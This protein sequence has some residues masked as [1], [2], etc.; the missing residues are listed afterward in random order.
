MKYIE[1]IMIGVLVILLALF[2]VP[3]RTEWTAET[4]TEAPLEFETEPVVETFIVETTEAERVLSAKTR[5]ITV[6]WHDIEEIH[7]EVIRI[8]K[9]GQI[10]SEETN[11]QETGKESIV[12]H[13]RSGEG[14]Q[15]FAETQGEVNTPAVEQTDGVQQAAQTAPVPDAE[16]AEVVGTVEAL[17]GD[18]LDGQPEGDA[19]STIPEILKASLDGAG[20]GWWYPYACAQIEQESHW[21]PWAVN[22]NNLDFGLLQFRI[23]FWGEPEDIFD[24]NAQIR[25]Y[26]QQVAA[27]IN[28]GLSVEEIISRHIT[29]D[30]VTEINWEYVNAVLQWL[31]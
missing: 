10:D 13:D 29:S 12:Q 14:N 18:S 3:N 27:R 26:T 28:A 20:I 2:A 8:R 23:T 11:E 6:T 1:V 25:K 24:V 30:Y 4:V 31:R 17:Q 7:A 5:T 22:P 16:P 15:I 21:N 9:T 19:A